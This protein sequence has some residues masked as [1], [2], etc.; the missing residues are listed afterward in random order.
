MI[1]TKIHVHVHV[2]YTVSN[3]FM[4]T[5]ILLHWWSMIDMCMFNVKFVFLAWKDI[6]MIALCMNEWIY[7]I[8]VLCLCHINVYVVVMHQ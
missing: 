7:I 5:A 8:H 3:Y 2:C 4:L 1:L 6:N